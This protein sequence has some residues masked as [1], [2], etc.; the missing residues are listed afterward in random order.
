M[1]PIIG[2]V[3]TQKCNFT[4]FLTSSSKNNIT[5]F[6]TNC[7]D[8][9]DDFNPFGDSDEEDPWARRKAKAKK[10]TKKSTKKA[11][12]NGNGST[13][14]TTA[15]KNIKTYILKLFREIKIQ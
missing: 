6:F 10:Q 2:T 15:G 8:D 9:E 11:N 3:H 5:T 12:K 7:S 13:T 14:N 1:I 4:S